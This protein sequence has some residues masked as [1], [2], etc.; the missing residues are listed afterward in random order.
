M[1]RTRQCNGGW[2][3]N[4]HQSIHDDSTVLLFDVLSVSHLNIN[5]ALLSRRVL[6]R[7][8]PKNKFI[9]NNLFFKDF[10][11]YFLYNKK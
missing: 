10:I 7:I 1:S 2:E 11:N 4:I 5:S 9:D 3:N 8:T 6:H